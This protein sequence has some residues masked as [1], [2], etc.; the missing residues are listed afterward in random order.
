MDLEVRSPV[1]GDIVGTAADMTDSVPDLVARARAA[2]REWARKPVAER[3]RNLGIIRRW[4]VRNRCAVVEST[5]AE[6]GKTY[7]DALASE[8]FVTADL[9]RFWERN[10]ERYLRD[11]R[12]RGGSPYVLGRR[13][14]V[15]HDPLGVVGVIAPWNYPLHIGL[16]DAIP[17]LAAGNT[18]VL[19]PSEITPLTTA[20][21]TEGIRA[22]GFPADVLLTATGPGATGAA[23]VDS[24][25]MVQFTGSTHTGRQVGVRCAERLIP[26]SLELGGKDP[27]IVCA[28]ANLDRAVHAA[29]T[30]GLA[31]SG[32]VCMSVERVYVEAPVYE[33]FSTALAD[34]VAGLRVRGGAGPGAA[35][36]GAIT[37]D[38]HV[39][40][41]V[42]KGARVLTGGKRKPGTARYFE[43]TVLADV[44]HDM[45][46]MREET[47]GPVLPVMKVRDV[48]EAVRLANDSEYGLTS[49]VYTRD[50]AKGAA[51]ARRIATG[52]GAVNDGYIHLAARHAPSPGV[53]NSG[54]G[55]PRNGRD[56]ILKYTAPHTIMTTRTGG[57]STELGWLGASPRVTR[58]AYAIMT[59]LYGRP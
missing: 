55:A 49:S 13:F 9:I 45:A 42:A 36:L 19:K 40:D 12:V 31:N 43:P 8:V 28:D 56:G 18:A 7:D 50:R 5:M 17:A 30:W 38:R 33:E 10:A 22:A 59:R 20:L 3:A 1:T 35:D 14:T 57:L 4:L 21:V 34:F 44:N 11:E 26:C 6:T 24:V 54:A 15:A 23:L 16:G 52:T 2:Q 37:F 27:M 47:F 51:V 25:D 41:A 29:A 46:V 58:A 53:R 39:A 32:Q 48:D